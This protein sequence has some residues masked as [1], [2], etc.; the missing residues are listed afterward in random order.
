[1]SLLDAFLLLNDNVHILKPPYLV[2]INY[3]L[4]FSPTKTKNLDTKNNN[5]R[6][7]FF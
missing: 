5:I 2:G 4:R 3:K 7:T 1:M 6:T